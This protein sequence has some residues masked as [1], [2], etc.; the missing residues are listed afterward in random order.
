MAT[1]DTFKGYADK[2]A[3]LYSVPKEIVHSVIQTESSWKPYAFGSQTS[4]GRAVGL[5][6]L[7]PATAKMLGVNPFVPEQN[8][9][10]GVKFLSQLYDQYG[11]WNDALA[12]YNA[13][14]KLDPGRGYAAKV[15]AGAGIGGDSATVL[16]AV[17]VSASPLPIDDGGDSNIIKDTLRSA[18]LW[19]LAVLLILFG[20][21]RLVN[22]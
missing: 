8:V 12:H 2:Y 15:L 10:G 22:A 13:G 4:S 11:N 1:I 6:Q 3:D 18:G 5:M 19:I 14:G 21:W 16:P 20:T 17:N 9:M 7:M